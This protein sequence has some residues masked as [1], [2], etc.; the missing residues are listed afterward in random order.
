MV[1]LCV[2]VVF[3]FFCFL[4]LFNHS[5]ALKAANVQQCMGTAEGEECPLV[6]VEELMLWAVAHCAS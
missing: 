1:V 3:L 6:A 2:C 4:F 5:G